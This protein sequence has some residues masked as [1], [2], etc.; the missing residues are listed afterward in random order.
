MDSFSL[1]MALGF[2]MIYLNFLIVHYDVLLQQ[3]YRDLFL[4][5]GCWHSWV[6]PC[7]ILRMVN[8]IKTKIETFFH[9]FVTISLI[10]LS[11]EFISKRKSKMKE[12]CGFNW[13]SSNTD[14]NLRPRFFYIF[15]FCFMYDVL[16]N[17]LKYC[18]ALNLIP[19]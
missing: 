17:G 1:C 14:G 11:I 19:L 2:F 9:E 10:S 3:Y 16:V 8:I 4:L 6:A 7:H 13:I 18:S 15:L 12:L 5:D